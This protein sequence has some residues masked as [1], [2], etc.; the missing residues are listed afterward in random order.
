[1]T[2]TTERPASAA[3]KAPRGN[4]TRPSLRGI[5]LVTRIELLRRRPSAK[6]YIFYGLIFAAIT[7]LGIVAAVM[8]GPEKNSVPLELVLVLVLGTGMLIGPSLAATSINGDS[9]EGVLAPLQM[10]RL[11]AGDLALGKLLASWIVAVLA[12]ITTVP[13]LL[14]A[15]S[16]SGW[17]LVELLTVLGVSLFVVL[18]FTAVGLAWSS[19]AARNAASVALTHVTTGFMVL[20]TLV[21]F[22]FTQPLVSEE[23]SQT[24][25][26]LD[27]A[28]MTTDQEEAVALAYETGNFDSVDWQSLPCMEETFVTSFAHTER[29]AWMLLVNPIVVIGESSPI[30]DPQ[31][32]EADG[33][34]YP[35][36]YAQM[37][38]GVSGARMGP[39]METRA[40]DECTGPV[41]TDESNDPWAI[42]QQEEYTYPR[43]PWL[44]LGVS[45]VLG[46]GAIIIAI[47][48]L[49]V[50]YKK[51]RAGTRVA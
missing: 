17:T 5:G 44:G 13:F 46:L 15:F 29:T 25:K 2:A 34:A 24:N 21:L 35:G 39:D 7:A 4:P 20:G 31:T 36:L 37:H 32:Y 1:M 9:A 23:V 18:V 45:A 41:A 16:R 30:I 40:Y 12:L 11:T 10:T 42:R 49:R 27:Y 6:G 28:Q 8:A 50:P 14:Y 51:L 3:P 48:R 26:F 22:F 43:D 47:R 19:L 38:K 33:R